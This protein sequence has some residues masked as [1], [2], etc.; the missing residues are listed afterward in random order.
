M[1]EYKVRTF[2]ALLIKTLNELKN[3]V[4]ERVLTGSANSWLTKSV[5][6]DTMI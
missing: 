5:M 1:G 6:S 3:I 2:Y 4:L